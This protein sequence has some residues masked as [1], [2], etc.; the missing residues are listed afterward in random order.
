MDLAGVAGAEREL[1][2]LVLGGVALGVRGHDEA[3]DA[4]PCAVLAQMIET[5]ACEP[6]VIH[7]LVPLSTTSRPCSSRAVV[8]MP[9]GFEPKSGSVS[10]KQPISCPRGEQ[11]QPVLLL[12]LGAEGV[13]RVHHQRAL[14]RGEGADARVAPLELLHD[15][16]VGDVVEPGAAVFPGR[17]APKKPSSAM[18]G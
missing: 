10:P 5:V 6:L 11:R 17:L 3:A 7:I 18:G 1:A 9:P 15:E 8:I 4:R 14:H 13:D 2:L 16:A 12:L